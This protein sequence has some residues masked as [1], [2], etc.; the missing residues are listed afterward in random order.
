V[1]KESINQLQCGLK[2]NHINEY[3]PNTKR[4]IAEKQE[5][6]TELPKENKQRLTEYINEAKLVDFN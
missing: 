5:E 6:S 4:A 2:R 3:H 1:L